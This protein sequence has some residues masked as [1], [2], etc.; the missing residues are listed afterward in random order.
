MAAALDRLASLDRALPL[1]V[2]DERHRVLDG[3]A[4]LLGNPWVCLA[5]LLALAILLSRRGRAGRLTVLGA[6][7][8]VACTDATGGFL[9]NVVARPRPCHVV[10]GL[11]PLAGCGD[12]FSFPSNHAAHAFA[13]ATVIAGRVPSW[14][15]AALGVA[16]LAA[17]ARLYA[18]AHYPSDVL[19]GALLGGAVGAATVFALARIG[20][21]RPGLLARPSPWRSG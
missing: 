2:Q 3:L 18:G 11:Q 7:L 5:P 16:A 12:A 6:V 8:A 17:L 21:A 13:L 15:W 14:R 10:V 9:K 19:A 1:W 20:S 4:M